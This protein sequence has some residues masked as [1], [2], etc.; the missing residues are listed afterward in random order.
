MYLGIYDMLI[1]IFGYFFNRICKFDWYVNWKILK[2]KHHKDKWLK[3]IG[4]RLRRLL[5]SMAFNSEYYWEDLKN[6]HTWTS[7]NHH[8]EEV[9]LSTQY[10]LMLHCRVANATQVLLHKSN[11]WKSE[12]MKNELNDNPHLLLGLSLSHLVA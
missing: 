11:W 1:I 9:Q 8:Y 3:E 6:Q 4:L 5:L 10:L 2:N 12:S 7:D